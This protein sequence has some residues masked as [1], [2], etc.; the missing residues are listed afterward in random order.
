MAFV[1]TSVLYLQQPLRALPDTSTLHW[2][3]GAVV[4]ANGSVRGGGSW[5]PLLRPQ[6][7]KSQPKTHTHRHS[8][9]QQKV[10]RVDVFRRM[11]DLRGSWFKVWQPHRP[12]HHTQKLRRAT[13]RQVSKFHKLSRA[14]KKVSIRC[15]APFSG[16][17]LLVFQRT[18]IIR[19]NYMS[20]P[21][22]PPPTLYSR[23]V[24]VV[25][26][27]SCGSSDSIRVCYCLLTFTNQSVYGGGTDTR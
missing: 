24:T 6:T 18:H 1:S 23:N 9:S 15:L 7:P 8:F 26:Y 2:D 19:Q 27:T 21:C 25:V 13:R 10:I 17:K 12:I 11:M 16:C 20:S 14:I 22:F 3:M 5:R 4:S